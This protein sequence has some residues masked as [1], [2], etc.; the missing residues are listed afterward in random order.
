LSSK[1]H[2]ITQKKKYT[3][4]IL[5]HSKDV[6]L[7]KKLDFTKDVLF[8]HPR[9]KPIEVIKDINKCHYIAS[10]SLHGLI[11]ADSYRIPNIHLKFS[12]KLKGGFHKFNDYYLGMDSKPEYIEYASSLTLSKIISNCKLRYTDNYLEKKQKQVMEIFKKC[13]NEIT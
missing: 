10:S 13:I 5:P 12:E 2:S 1:I 4:G 7:V 3:L 6:E 9:R 8:I 11:F